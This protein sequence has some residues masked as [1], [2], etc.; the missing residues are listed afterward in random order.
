MLTLRTLHF[1]YDM[2]LVY[3]DPIQRCHFT[4]K[5]MPC[6]TKRQRV[7]KICIEV[8][9]HESMEQGEDSFG[10]RLLFGNVQTAHDRFHFHI[11]GTVQTGLADADPVDHE[12]MLSVF[13]YPYGLTVPGREIQAYYERLDADEPVKDSSDFERAVFLMHSVYRDFSYEKGVTGVNTGAE[14]A[15]QLG[16][17]VCQDYAHIL[18][19]LCRLS[20]IKARYVTGM[21]IGEG[22][23][24]AWVEVLSGGLWYAL[25]PTN[26][27]I[28]TDSH[29]KIGVGRDASDCMI[30]RGIMMGNASQ[31]QKIYVAV[32]EASQAAHLLQR[33]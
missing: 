13:A 23:S 28:V 9:P 17:G 6:S 16:K 24:H 29:I 2:Q 1:E 5:C 8:E 19:A 18:I 27:C 33:Y 25:D 21:L 32:T 7:E 22:Y 11:S 30:N 15:W 12:N 10:N 4:I 20:G 26:D 14:E 31:E 3:S